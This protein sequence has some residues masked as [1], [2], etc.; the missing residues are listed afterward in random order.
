LPAARRQ[1]VALQIAMEEARRPFDLERGPL[2]RLGLLR[3]DEQEHAA[4]LTMHHIISDQW[5]MGIFFRE[6]SALYDAF[7]QGRPSPL[8]DLP[9][10]YADYSHWQRQWLTGETLERQVAY[11]RQQLAGALSQ[12]RD[13]QS[14]V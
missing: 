13:K 14:V 6:L 8:P 10:Q 4:L 2:L 9:V 5:S 3:L 12:F 1:E 7:A 11:W